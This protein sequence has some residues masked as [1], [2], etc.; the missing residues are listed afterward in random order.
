MDPSGQ[1]QGCSQG[2][3]G[4]DP[5]ITEVYKFMPPDQLFDHKLIYRDPLPNSVSPNARII[6][7]GDAAHSYVFTS[8]G[9]NPSNQ[10]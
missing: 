3:E 4:W 5:R 8:A 1:A 9:G 7:I 10:R 6:L 2:G